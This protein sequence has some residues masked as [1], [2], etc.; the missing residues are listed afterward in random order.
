MVSGVL[1]GAAVAT[2]IQTG[3]VSVTASVTIGVQLIQ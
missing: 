1:A 2:P 3:T